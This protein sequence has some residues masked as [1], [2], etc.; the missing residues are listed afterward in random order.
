ME[1][2]K[3][4]NDQEVSQ[5]FLV[6]MEAPDVTENHRDYNDF[7]VSALQCSSSQ[8]NTSLKSSSWS[9]SSS[10]SDSSSLEGSMRSTRDGGSIGELLQIGSKE[11]LSFFCQP[12]PGSCGLGL[13]KIAWQARQ[14]FTICI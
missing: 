7:E 12:C 4:R 2:E 9:V 1:L 5:S 11:P 6:N 8:S 13:Q 14:W 3:Y 10:T